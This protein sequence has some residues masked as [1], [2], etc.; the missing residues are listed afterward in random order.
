MSH[1]HLGRG[2]ARSQLPFSATGYPI[3]FAGKVQF[4]V[5]LAS[6]HSFRKT[7]PRVEK[8]PSC[9]APCT[10]C[11]FCASNRPEFLSK[12]GSLKTCLA[13]RLEQRHFIRFVLYGKIN[14]Q[15]QMIL[16][17]CFSK[18][19]PWYGTVLECCLWPLVAALEII[20]SS[21]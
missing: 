11:W 5:S 19:W 8:H 2:K 16:V 18:C 17:R 6:G 20:C 12:R 1:C 15:T 21:P 7:G 14:F 10:W 9:P 3:W 4:G 13:V